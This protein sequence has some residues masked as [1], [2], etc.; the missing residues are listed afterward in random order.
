M[1]EEDESPEKVGQ[2]TT[3]LLPQLLAPILTA[4]TT[5]PER[6]RES[7]RTQT[8]PEKKKKEERKVKEEKKRKTKE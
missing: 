8:S 6:E 1:E 4:R 2:F 5:F 3:L 7:E